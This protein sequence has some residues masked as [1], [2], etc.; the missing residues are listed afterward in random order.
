M[1]ANAFKVGFL[2]FKNQ[3]KTNALERAK[4]FLNKNDYVV[5][6]KPKEP[7]KDTKK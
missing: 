5:T 6:K 7:K 4:D 3:L 2:A 1:K